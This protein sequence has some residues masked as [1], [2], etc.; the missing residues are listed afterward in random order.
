[1]SGGGSVEYPSTSDRLALFMRRYALTNDKV[2]RHLD[3]SKEQLH[4]YLSSKTRRIKASTD[5]ADTAVEK[6]LM[7]YRVALA[8]QMLKSATTKSLMSLEG[9]SRRSMAPTQLGRSVEDRS[10]V[11][12]ADAT[13]AQLENAAMEMART[14]VVKRKRKRRVHV[15]PLDAPEASLKI[16]LLGKKVKDTVDAELTAKWLSVR[17]TRQAA[18]VELICPIRVDVDMNGKRFQDTFIIDAALTTCAPETLAARI[19]DDEKMS[20]KLKDVIAESIR[21]QVFM[22]TTCFSIK[23]KSDRLFPI[24]LDL[25]IDGFSLRDQF[26][27]DISNDYTAAQTFACT[28]C[29]DMTLPQQFEPA[30]VFS[31]VEQVAAYRIVLGGHRWVGKNSCCAKDASGTLPT[32]SAGYIETMPPLDNVVRDTNDA[33]LW[34]PVLSEL[35]SEE[36][37]YLSAKL[38]A[39][40]APSARRKAPVVSRANGPSHRPTRPV[41]KETRLP[42][43]LNPFIVY[44]QMQKEVLGKTR[45]SASEMRKIMGD[46]WRRCSDE[47]KEYYA[48]VTETENEKRRRDYILHLR[49]RAIA[50]WEEDE[51]RRKGLLAS[52][53]L[54]ASVDHFRGLLLENY[55]SER[56]E[57]DV[58]RLESVAESVDE[59]DEDEM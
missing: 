56:H 21:R 3:W 47:E 32:C 11:I 6:L 44:C 40:R 2:A 55:M 54:E 12:H 45:R 33:K 28:L 41:V 24:Y 34:Q 5:I 36:R 29:A 22:Y 18:D 15:M 19:V 53:T 43:P 26:E 17:K 39:I 38:P 25:I 16:P 37:T 30:I 52:T 49:D 42:R 57:V 1:M 50:E 9:T 46:M 4:A 23:D 20:D 48:Q 31:I 14:S 59:E 51:A 13:P 27:W 58:N 35:S 10:S 7:R 8:H